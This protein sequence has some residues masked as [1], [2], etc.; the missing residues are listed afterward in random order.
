MEGKNVLLAIVLST[1]VL[2][3]WATFF[4]PDP[5]ER[6]ITE[7]QTTKNEELSSP[8]IEEVELSKK[9]ER[10]ETSK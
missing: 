8:S 5:I 2:I 4:E 6:Q 3:V 10:N 1:L 7:D 9:V